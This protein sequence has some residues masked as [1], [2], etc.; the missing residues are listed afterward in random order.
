MILKFNIKHSKK[1]EAIP[2]C[3]NGLFLF[4]DYAYHPH[5]GIPRIPSN[6]IVSMVLVNF[7]YQIN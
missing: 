4:Y 1:K 3:E 6:I 7:I 5:V 2:V